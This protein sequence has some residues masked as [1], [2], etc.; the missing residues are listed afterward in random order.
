[1]SYKGLQ[2]G[3]WTAS[4][5]SPEEG[6]RQPSVT[7]DL[8]MGDSGE[9]IC[10]WSAQ[11]QRRRL[12][13]Q[14]VSAVEI[15]DAHL[16]RIDLLDRELNLFCF[17]YEDEARQEAR[18]LDQA[19]VRGDEPRP[20]HG[21]P[22]ALKDFTPTAGRTTTLG[23]V[24][25]RDWIPAEDPPVVERLRDAGG[26]LIGKTTTAELAHSSFTRSKLWGVSRNPIDPS[27]TTGGSSGG[28]AGAVAA[29]MVPLAEGS[30]AGGSVRI[31]AA[32]CGV[33]GF[34][35]SH[36]RIPMHSTG[37]DYEQIFH[38]GPIARTVDDCAL[39]F[40][41]M[42]GP[43]DRD[44]LSC[45]HPAQLPPRL[46]GDVSGLKVGVTVDLGFYDVHPEVETNTTR[47][48][49]GLAAD[50]A[51]VEAVD[52][53]WTRAVNDGWVDY[54]SVALAA[55][56]GK[57]ADRHGQDM[58]PSLL[59]LISRGRSISALDFK[60]LDQLRTQQ[61]AVLREVLSTHD[62]LLCPTLAIPVP[63]AEEC[64]DSYRTVSREGRLA[65]FEMTCPFN[66]VPQCPVISVPS[67]ASSDG[68][69]TAVQLVGRR[70]ADVTVLEA[71]SAVERRGPGGR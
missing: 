10:S 43:D 24:A 2:R 26:I 21:L 4:R 64:A 14:D 9:D 17:V 60:R 42:Q 63:A 62:V 12:L 34:K 71:A 31:P 35:P 30:D 7:S 6:H 46:A 68:L 3:A 20:L 70:Y 25:F 33:V 16:R 18:N 56:Y 29:K 66:F 28:S 19:L 59:R 44:P 48:A 53:A 69:P 1:M 22:Y 27:R 8:Q 32:C 54:W 61:W 41:V 65:S 67:G 37:N 5:S 51:I 49:D 13:Q 39:M 58:E 47:I 55:M 45:E 36:G 50:G 38:H 40:S 11:E 57:V 52:L 23:S 15:V